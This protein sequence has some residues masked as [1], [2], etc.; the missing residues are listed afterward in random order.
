MSCDDY[1]CPMCLENLQK[2]CVCLKCKHFLCSIC[3]TKLKDTSLKN[4][5]SMLCPT[6]RNIEILYIPPQ[7][8]ELQVI[9]GYDIISIS[10]TPDEQLIFEQTFMR[11]RILLFVYMI[12]VV[13]LI[14]VVCDRAPRL[15]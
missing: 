14:G 5:G 3:Y 4:N 15:L 11:D 1:C 2:D 6:C 13:F 9:V 12:A 8:R 10:Q 7:P